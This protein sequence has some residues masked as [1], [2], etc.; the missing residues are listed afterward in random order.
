[1]AEEKELRESVLQLFEA[2]TKLLELVLTDKEVQERFEKL[3]LKEIDFYEYLSNLE[4]QVAKGR[5]ITFADLTYTKTGHSWKD[6]IGKIFNKVNSLLKSL[7]LPGGTGSSG[8]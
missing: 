3:M 1:M 4:K 2:H 6:W 5:E 7:I 8:G